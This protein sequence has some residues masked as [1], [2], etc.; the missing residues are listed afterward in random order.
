MTKLYCGIGARATPP[1]VLARMAKIATILARKSY[2]LRSGGAEGADRAFEKGAGRSEIFLAGNH[3]PLWTNIFTEHFHPNPDALKEY[4]R[5]LMNRNALQLLGLDG[6][7]PVEFVVCWTANGKDSGG[8]GHA[9]R[10]ARYFGIPV[11]NLY[12]E[13]ETEMLK[14]LIRRMQ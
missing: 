9:C 7:T 12:N 5:Q 4:P 10:I 2:T 6:N 13:D 14:S 3:L 1:D 11:Y 8:T